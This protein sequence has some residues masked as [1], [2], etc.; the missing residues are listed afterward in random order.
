MNRKFKIS[1]LLLL[2]LVSIISAAGTSA[3]LKEQ[4]ENSINVSDIIS[5]SNVTDSYFGKLAREEN[6]SYTDRS[7][8]GCWSPDGSKVLVLTRYAPSDAPELDAMYLLNADGTEPKEIIATRNNTMEKSLELTANEDFKIARWNSAGDHFS[9]YGNVVNVTDTLMV[10]DNETFI[11]NAGVNIIGIADVDRNSVEAI[12][13][14]LSDIS[15]WDW[16]DYEREF[17]WEPNGTDA[18]MILNGDLCV[19]ENY[20]S[21]L[22]QINDSEGGISECMWNH[23]GDSIAFIEGSLWTTDRHTG[24][25]L[26]KLASN[27]DRLVGWSQ[28]DSKIYYSSYENDSCSQYVVQLN[29]SKITKISTG[30]LDD[31]MLIGPD[32]KILFTN[33]SFEDGK[34]ISSSLSVA[35]ADGTDKK[36]LDENASEYAYL[37]SKASWSP[38]GD[39]IATAFNIINANGSEKY[40]IELGNTFSWHPSGDYIAFEAVDSVGGINTTRVCVANSDGSGITQVSP[41]D[42]YSYSFDGWSPDGSRMLITKHDTNYTTEELL[43]VRFSGFDEIMSLRFKEYAL[44]GKELLIL[45]K[46][47]SQPVQNALVTLDGKEIGTTDENGHLNYTVS[48]SGIHILNASKE[49]YF[50]SGKELTVY[51]DTYSSVKDG[52][53]SDTTDSPEGSVST[54][55]T[56]LRDWLNNLTGN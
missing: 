11:G 42:N 43:A 15:K 45:V 23:K 27:A 53:V 21:S 32:G 29:D 31:Y 13:A 1:F 33:T 3:A 17:E 10:I 2:F 18:V 41:D 4:T 7:L 44:P 39:K 35:D 34:V 46:S 9:F 48:E 16:I 19:V 54:M 50:A 47:M 8:L 37:I 38:D 51:G 12:G 28:D 22:N 5:I 40:D 6:V 49:G 36:M 26:K 55:P 25:D 52:D 30:S 14:N 56:P 20:V 24:D